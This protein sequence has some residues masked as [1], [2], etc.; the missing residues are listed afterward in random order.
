MDNGWALLG[1]EK[2]IVRYEVP[3]HLNGVDD[4]EEMRARDLEALN[5][6]L[7]KRG[8]SVDAKIAEGVIWR[9][10][11]PGMILDVRGSIGVDVSL[12]YGSSLNRKIVLRARPIHPPR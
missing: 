11:F 5:T 6:E 10:G 8:S 7:R 2:L 1:F 3:E 4:I 12:R 9:R